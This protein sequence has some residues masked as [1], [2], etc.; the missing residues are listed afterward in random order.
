MLAIEIERTITIRISLDDEV[1]SFN[2]KRYKIQ[3]KLTMLPML[4]HTELVENQR[5][6]ELF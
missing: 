6:T 2:D 5:V 4:F 1:N 3:I